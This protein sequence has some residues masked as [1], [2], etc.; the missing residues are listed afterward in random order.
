MSGW[1]WELRG[2]LPG[3]RESARKASRSQWFSSPDKIVAEQ[4]LAEELCWAQRAGRPAERRDGAGS[5]LAAGKHR[6]SVLQEEEGQ[7]GRS[8]AVRVVEAGDGREA[9]HQSCSLC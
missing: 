6:L 3:G 8:G 9:G 1:L 7:G 5:R 4:G 2:A